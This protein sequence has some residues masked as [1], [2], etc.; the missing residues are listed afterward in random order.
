MQRTSS[1]GVAINHC[2][3]QYAHGNLAFGG[4]NHA[5]LGSAHGQFGFKAFSHA[6]AVLESGPVMVAKLFFPP[7]TALTK[8]IIRLVVDSLRWPSLF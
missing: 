3:L 5:G 7:F 8:K 2:V 1:G 6:R 4:V